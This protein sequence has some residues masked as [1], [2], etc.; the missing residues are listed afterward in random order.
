ML[1]ASRHVLFRLLLRFA[2]AKGN[3]IPRQN[4]LERFDESQS[5]SVSRGLAELKRRHLVSVVPLKNTPG[6]WGQPFTAPDPGAPGVCYIPRFGEIDDPV[7]ND[8]LDDRMKAVWSVEERKLLRDPRVKTQFVASL[9]ASLKL[10]EPNQIELFQTLIRE[11]SEIAERLS[12]LSTTDPSSIPQAHV[13]PEEIVDAT[14]ANFRCL[15]SGES[16]P[17]QEL[18]RFSLMLRT[19]GEIAVKSVV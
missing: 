5:R 18:R 10:L 14:L 4:I 1:R 6:R 15:D 8:Q 17:E 12:F 3:P 13:I 19:S 16:L 2:L 9:S 11:V 7:L